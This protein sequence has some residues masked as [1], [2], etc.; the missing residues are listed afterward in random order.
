MVLS[1]AIFGSGLDETLNAGYEFTTDFILVAASVVIIALLKLSEKEYDKEFKRKVKTI[2]LVSIIFPLVLC[3]IFRYFLLV[4]LPKE[5]LVV[6]QIL[7]TTYYS[8]AGKKEVK[9]GKAL[10]ADETAELDDAF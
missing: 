1:I 6:E 2:I 9:E 8:Y 5:G 10:S 3:P 7:N 4:P